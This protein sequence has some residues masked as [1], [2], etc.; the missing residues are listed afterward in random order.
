MRVR[1]RVLDSLS[2]RPQTLDEL[3]NSFE[4]PERALL[5]PVVTELIESG[6]V[7]VKGEGKTRILSSVT[8]KARRTSPSHDVKA[9]SSL[10]ATL[11]EVI[12][13]SNPFVESTKSAFHRLFTDT[14]RELKV[15]QP[16]IDPFFVEIFSDDLRLLAE[17]GCRL[18]LLTRK[19]EQGSEAQKAILRMYEIFATRK[20]LGGSLE[21][22]EHWYPLRGKDGQ[23]RQFIGLHAKVMLN[24]E[25]AYVGSANWTEYS[26]GNNVEFGLVLT[27]AALI[28]E[29]SETLALV[30]ISSKKVDL[31]VMHRNTT[32]RTGRR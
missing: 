12:W 28:R 31:A 18:V 24:E 21:V 5:G 16:F 13:S 11:P 23:Q 10:A 30:L 32:D 14:K 26:L 1:D 19:I 27:D 6:E 17:R 7:A 20:S 2:A 8:P 3:L 4:G 15:S 9:G 29:L 22:Y 25:K